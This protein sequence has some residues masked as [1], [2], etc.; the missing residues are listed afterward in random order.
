MKYFQ[1]NIALLFVLL[2]SCNH[3]NGNKLEVQEVNIGANKDKCLLSVEVLFKNPSKKYDRISYKEAYILFNDEH[4]FPY[5]IDDRGCVINKDSNYCIFKFVLNN[6]VVDKKSLKTFISKL[7]LVIKIGDET[8]TSDISINS[9]VNYYFE[10][11]I[12]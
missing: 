9:N 6:T 8:Y 3:N 2:L 1:N 5:N 11:E 4:Y 10:D 12:I 7:K